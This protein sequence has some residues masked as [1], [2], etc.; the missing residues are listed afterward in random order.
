MT[1]MGNFIGLVGQWGHTDPQISPLLLV[2][3]QSSTVKPY[4]WG[5]H[6]FESRNKNSALTWS[7]T[8]TG[9]LLQCWKLLSVPLE[10]E[11]NQSS[12]AV[13]AARWHHNQPGK[14]YQQAQQ[15]HECGGSNPLLSDGLK[16]HSSNET[17]QTWQHYQVQASVGRQI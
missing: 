7:F 9:S 5:H 2:M 13:E 10:E 11:R 16:A 3:L 6:I 15:Q 17:N 4:C 12:P 8:V 14:G 1:G